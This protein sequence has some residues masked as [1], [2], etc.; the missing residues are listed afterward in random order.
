MPSNN[1]NDMTN[2]CADEAHVLLRGGGA[3]GRPV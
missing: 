3:Q 1:N 2:I